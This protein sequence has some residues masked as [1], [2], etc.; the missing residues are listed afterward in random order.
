M[1]Q[2]SKVA[3]VLALSLSGLNA[4]ALEELEFHP[5]QND[6]VIDSKIKSV[7]KAGSMTSRIRA[8]DPINRVSYQKVLL[9][10][11]S[12]N[13]NIFKRDYT[14]SRYVTVYNVKKTT[15]KVAYLPFFEEDCYD[16]SFFMASWGE[17]RTLIVKLESSVGVKGLGLSASVRMSISEGTT[18][19][20]S[21]RVKA[22]K[23]IQARHYPY[24]ISERHQGVTYIQTFN[25]KTGGYGFL[26]GRG[27][28]KR[29]GLDNQNVG[30]KVK[31][32]VI[33]RCSN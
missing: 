30:F 6:I 13:N 28:P 5:L 17:S 31:R 10:P 7:S 12:K 14:H 9:G 22:T 29:F 33:G 32:E 2:I 21:R 1:F 27:Y 16:D 23:N 19:S 11:V 15:E 20:T 25:A 8:L 26:R 4:L 3:F 18:F 24:K